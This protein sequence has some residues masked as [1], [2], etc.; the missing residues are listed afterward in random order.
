MSS[1]TQVRFR[2]TDSVD[3][4]QT[5]S[6]N[7]TTSLST[8]SSPI[9]MLASSCRQTFEELSQILHGISPDGEDQLTFDLDHTHAL[10]EDAKARFKAWGTNIAAFRNGTLRT[11]LDF[12]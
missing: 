6:I 12:R 1:R 4:A 8:E 2:S 9:Y 3:D 5:S 11:S 7:P 10:I